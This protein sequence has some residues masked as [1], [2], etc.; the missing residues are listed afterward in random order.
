MSA[1]AARHGFRRGIALGTLAV[2]LFCGGAEAAGLGD[3]PHHS[4]L[5]LD[6]AAPPAHH[7][8]AAPGQVHAGG[9]H[10]PPSPGGEPQGPCTCVGSC[11]AG[12]G[13]PGLV[14]GV[15]LAAVD[16]GARTPAVSSSAALPRARTPY[17]LPFPHGP[18]ALRIA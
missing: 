6:T 4:R 16:L 2:F 12:A 10:G 13:L 17:L 18:P 5:A 9:H 1:R 11:S 15:A 14:A 7:P 3:C 8:H